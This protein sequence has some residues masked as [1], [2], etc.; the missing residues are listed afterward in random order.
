[1]WACVPLGLVR[2]HLNREIRSGQLSRSTVS[3][4][5]VSQWRDVMV[6]P[7]NFRKLVRLTFINSPTV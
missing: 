1:M 2:S 3:M 5:T 4:G 6:I 7:Y